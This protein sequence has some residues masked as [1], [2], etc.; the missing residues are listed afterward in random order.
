MSKNSNELNYLI[1]FKTQMLHFID[2][3]RQIFPNEPSFI[4]IRIFVND[5]I[6]VKDVIGRFMLECLPVSR[7]VK[8]RNDKFFIY[9]DFIFEKYADDVGEDEIKHFRQIWESEILDDEN[10][11]VIWRWLDMFMLIARKYYDRF[12]SVEGWEFDLE[13]DTDKMNRI[14]YPEDYLNK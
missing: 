5:K 1:H 7:A 3:L 14:I 8:E 11:E 13:A 2:E 12:G 9:S 6:P 4:I 10:K